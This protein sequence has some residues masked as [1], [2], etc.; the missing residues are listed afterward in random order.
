MNAGSELC[1]SES[2]TPVALWSGAR[3]GVGGGGGRSR[4]PGRRQREPSRR[5]YRVCR[6]VRKVRVGN[7]QR[8]NVFRRQIGW[9]HWKG[10]RGVWGRER[11]PGSLQV[12]GLSIGKVRLAPF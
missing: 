1:F 4:C 7:D 6:P 8:L 11:R 10:E 12:S 3:G 2:I 9:I 5:R